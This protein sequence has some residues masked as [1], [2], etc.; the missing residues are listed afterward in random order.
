MKFFRLRFWHQTIGSFLCSHLLMLL[1]PYSMLIFPCYRYLSSCWKL[2]FPYRKLA[3]LI[4][5]AFKVFLFFI[6]FTTVF[7]SDS[8]SITH[9]L[10]IDFEFFYWLHGFIYQTYQSS[11]WDFNLFIW[12]FFRFWLLSIKLTNV[13]LSEFWY[14][15]HIHKIDFEVSSWF[16]GVICWNYQARFLDLRSLLSVYPKNRL[17]CHY[18]WFLSLF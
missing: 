9:I 7:P 10:S 17:W 6:I 8:I 16:H 4:W 15:F 18:L 11:F 2:T 14:S 12:V 5:A 3:P 1:F 13:Y